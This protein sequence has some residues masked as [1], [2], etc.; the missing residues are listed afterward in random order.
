[1]IIKL[2]EKLIGKRKE[3][4]SFVQSTVKTELKSYS[5]GV[6]QSWKAALAQKKIAAA[7]KKSADKK[8]YSK[9]VVIYGMQ[10]VCGVDSK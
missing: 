4:I 7:V 3:E 8:D 9:N 5:A 1:M 6:S 10:K 2:Q